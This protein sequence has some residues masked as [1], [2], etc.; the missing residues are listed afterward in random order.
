MALVTGYVIYETQGHF[1]DPEVSER[2]PRD[3]GHLRQAVAVGA[4]DY[5]ASFSAALAA[6]LRGLPDP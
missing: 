6:Y 5:G 3:L 4:I 1:T 2:L